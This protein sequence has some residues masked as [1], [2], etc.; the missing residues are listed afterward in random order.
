MLPSPTGRDLPLFLSVIF[1]KPCLTLILTSQWSFRRVSYAKY[2]SH[3]GGIGLVIVGTTQHSR[4]SVDGQQVNLVM[5]DYHVPTTEPERSK[6]IWKL[7]FYFVHGRGCIAAQR[8]SS[9]ASRRD[10]SCRRVT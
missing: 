2:C 9:D 6:P 10:D 5:L 7:G 3:G 4:F 1:N 8:E